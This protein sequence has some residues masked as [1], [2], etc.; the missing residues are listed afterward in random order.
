M[1]N[2]WESLNVGNENYVTITN[3]D[4]ASVYSIRVKA[5]NQLGAG[6]PSDI[7]QV[8]YPLNRSQ[9]DNY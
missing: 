1:S 9:G 7:I 3:I 4:P 8:I 2:E 6:E 5:E